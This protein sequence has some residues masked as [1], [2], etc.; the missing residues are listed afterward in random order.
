MRNSFR[1]AML[2][3]AVVFAPTAAFADGPFGLTM[4]MTKTEIEKTIGAELTVVSEQ[5]L[6]FST[7]T[8]PRG[9]SSFEAYALQIL[10]KA[11]L[12]QIR[13]VGKDIATSSHGLQLK[14]KFQETLALIE[15]VYGA[16]EKTDRL[17]AGS[18]WNEP[19][20]WMTG[21]LKKERFLMAVW[22][23]KSESTFKNE[24]T[25]VAL[26]ARAKARGAGY[27]FLQYE[28]SNAAQCDDER[29]EGERSAF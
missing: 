15:D 23:A 12:C 28:F 17:L 20:D 24:V 19:E 1:V 9:N 18:I 11:G 16:P 7:T 5:P 25:E 6:L 26:A 21:M 29:K 13:A 10:P 3:V 8:V 2:A 22:S 4:G 14:A 27:L